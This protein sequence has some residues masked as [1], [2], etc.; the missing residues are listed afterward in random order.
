MDKRKLMWE[1]EKPAPAGFYVCAQC[2]N[3]EQTIYHDTDGKKLPLCPHC[4][5]TLWLKI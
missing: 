4:K 3:G 5:K 1:A 2:K